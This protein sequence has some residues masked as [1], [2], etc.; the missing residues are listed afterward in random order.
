MLTKWSLVF[1]R[2]YLLIDKADSNKTR[3]DTFNEKAKSLTLPVQGLMA[4]VFFCF[5]FF[6]NS[7]CLN[8]VKEVILFWF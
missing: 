5:F 2:T 7:E 6:D 4:D 1:K 8:F 3:T